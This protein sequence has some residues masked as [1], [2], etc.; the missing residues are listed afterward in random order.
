MLADS[1]SPDHTACPHSLIWGFPSPHLPKN[2]FSLG[3]ACLASALSIQKVLLFFLLLHE[4][5]I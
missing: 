3:G 5:I 2:M 4:K 1:E